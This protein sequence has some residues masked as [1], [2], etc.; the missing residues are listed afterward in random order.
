V[1]T[2][3]LRAD[4]VDWHSMAGWKRFVLM[5]LMVAVGDITKAGRI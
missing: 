2:L 4:P 1:L 3:D 5:G